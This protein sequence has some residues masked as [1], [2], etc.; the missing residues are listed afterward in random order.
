MAI[1][2]ASLVR[3]GPVAARLEYASDQVS[4]TFRVYRDGVLIATTAA[5][6]LDV[7]FGRGEYPV[8]EV[9]D[10]A[11]AP[12]LC[13]PDRATVQWRGQGAG[14]AHYRVEQFVGAAWAV[15]ARVPE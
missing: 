1:T 15:K 10:D 12:G 2:S 13:Y 14:I 4:P 5:T 9:Y 8:F 6:W 7:A 3:T 11:T